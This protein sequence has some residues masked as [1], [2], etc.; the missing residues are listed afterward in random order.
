MKEPTLWISCDL[1]LLRAYEV[2]LMFHA[3]LHG[4]TS[5]HLLTRTGHGM[6]TSQLLHNFDTTETQ[7]VFVVKLG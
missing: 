1:L 2:F 7:F 5:F 6:S 4:Y 3:P